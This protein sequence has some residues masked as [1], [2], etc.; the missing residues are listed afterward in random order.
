VGAFAAN[1][2]E[3]LSGCSIPSTT[4]RTKYLLDCEVGADVST[5]LVEPVSGVPLSSVAVPPPLE[6]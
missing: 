5:K 2:N 4:A 1:V 3:A 6:R